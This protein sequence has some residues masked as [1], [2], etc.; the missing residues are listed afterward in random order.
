MLACLPRRLAV[1]LVTL[2]TFVTVATAVPAQAA[3]TPPAGLQVVSTSASAVRVTW[4][5][6]S[7]VSRYRIQYATSSSM[8]NANYRRFSGTSGELSG[9]VS[10]QTYYIKVR[11]ITADGANLS[12]YSAAIK[13]RTRDSG[14]YPFLSP[15]AL[16]ASASSET[17]L[18]VTWAARGTDNRYRISWATTSGFTDPGYLRVT[19]TKATVTGLKAGTRYY[20]K[21]RVIAP[22]GGNLSAYSTPVTATTRAK[23]GTQN[24]TQ[25]SLQAPAGLAVSKAARTSVEVSWKA[26]AGAPRYRVQYATTPTMTGAAELQ[27]TG[28]SLEITGLDPGT[29]YHI[30]VRVITAAGVSLSPYTAAVSVTTSKVA[31]GPS[32]LR[33]ATYN[34]HCANC[35]AGLANEL[36]WYQRRDSVVSTVLTQAPDVIGFQ[37]ASQG[38]LKDGNGKPLSDLAQFEDLVQRLGNPYKLTNPHRNN[39]VKST[40]PTKCVYSNRGASQGVKIVYNSAVL[41][42]VN[43]GSLQLSQISKSDNERYLAWAILEVKQTGHR[44]FFGDTHLEPTK[45]ASGD[46]SYFNLRVAQT[47]EILAEVAKRNPAK[48]PTLIVGDFNSHKWTPPS[49]G[50]YD[51]MRSAGYVDPLGNSYRSTRT[52]SGATAARRIRA[53]FSSYNGFARKAPSFGYLNGTYLDYIWTSSGVTVEEWET[54]VNVDAEGSFVGVIPS[55]HNMLRA[56]VLLP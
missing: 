5:A 3:T 12:P 32:P 42:L 21:V 2:A 9:L 17:A 24:P 56:D 48:L 54:V 35:F 20:L 39:C 36:T 7:G 10:D 28:T 19:G 33:I 4:R 25:S 22:D 31:P 47:K 44:F 52:T 16:A 8:A 14:E 11:A 18:A 50:P 37:E 38:W 1:L 46:S 23:G 43:Q 27:A 41:R 29:T 53:N 51:T 45:D 26:V 34:V 40:T 49:N 55:D 13:A 30:K 6:I 15:A